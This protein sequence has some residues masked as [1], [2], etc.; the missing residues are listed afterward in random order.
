MLYTQKAGT[1][2]HLPLPELA[3]QALGRVKR[4]G[5]YLFWSG[6]GTRKSAVAAWERSLK[7]LFKLA[8]ITGHAHRFRDTFAVRLLENSVSLE[9]VAKLLGN[10]ARVAEKHYSPWVKSRQTALDAEVRRT[11]GEGEVGAVHL[12]RA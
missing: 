8:G 7:M 4:D 5:D 11:F 3:I 10:T 9:N 2:V 12:I 6:N 1:P